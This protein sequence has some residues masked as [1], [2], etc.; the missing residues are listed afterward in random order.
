[1]N[2]SSISHYLGKFR[3]SKATLLQPPQSGNTK[4]SNSQR[5]PSLSHT[6]I[7]IRRI[8]RIR[9]AHSYNCV[10]VR[11]HFQFSIRQSKQALRATFSFF[12]QH[13]I[14]PFPS[15]CLVAMAF[16]AFPT[17]NENKHNQNRYIYFIHCAAVGKKRCES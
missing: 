12:R 3:R 17:E 14:H 11:A 8:Q 10:R 7:R 13:G 16:F 9:I 1:M 5:P 4:L 15:D 2:P 6:R